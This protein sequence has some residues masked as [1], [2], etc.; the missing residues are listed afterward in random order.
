[1]LNTTS[2]KSL[3]T[4]SALPNKSLPDKLGNM[5]DTLPYKSLP[6]KLGNKPDNKLDNKLDSF[7]FRLGKLDRFLPRM[8]GIAEQSLMSHQHGAMV[9]YNGSP[10]AWAFNTIKGG[11]TFHAEMEAIGQFLTNRGFGNFVRNVQCILYGSK[12]PRLKI[13]AFKETKAFDEEN[14]HYCGPMEWHQVYH[15]QAV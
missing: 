2:N 12:K 13:P 11:N 6:S 3:P 4:M 9:I 7:P 10:A 1:M 15:V 5:L 14:L 8:I